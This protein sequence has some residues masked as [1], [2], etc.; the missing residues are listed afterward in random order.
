MNEPYTPKEQSKEVRDALLTL[1]A[2]DNR[3]TTVETID[4]WRA[5]AEDLHIVVESLLCYAPSYVRE[6]ETAY[7]SNP[8]Q[9]ELITNKV[10]AYLE[11]VTERFMVPYAA[12]EKQFQAQ[13]PRT[14]PLGG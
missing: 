1:I 10:K 14:T 3:N 6:L 13:L 2:W 11:H 8:A 5:L 4:N 12:A 7:A 9:R